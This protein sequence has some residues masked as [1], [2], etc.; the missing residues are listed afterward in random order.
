MIKKEIEFYKEEHSDQTNGDD[1][2]FSY[3][4][5]MVEGELKRSCKKAGIDGHNHLHKFR[6][7]FAS[8]LLRNGGN[9]IA[10]SKLMRHATPSMTLNVYSHVLPDDLGET[11]K[12]LDNGK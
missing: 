7:S 2:I 1:K 4:I 3:T 6:H 11:L 10:V 12:L 5:R 8:N 9:I